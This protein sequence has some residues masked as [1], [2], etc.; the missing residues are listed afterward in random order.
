M[1]A[2]FDIRFIRVYDNGFC[3]VAEF[4]DETY[5]YQIENRIFCLNEENLRIRIENRKKYGWK[6]TEEMKGL[7]ELENAAR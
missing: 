6:I 5:A 7:W 4:E 1:P 3:L 2:Y